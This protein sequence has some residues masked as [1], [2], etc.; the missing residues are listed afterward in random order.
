[1]SSDDAIARRRLVARPVLPPGPLAELKNALYGMYLSADAPAVARIRDRIRELADGDEASDP[2]AAPSNDAIHAVLS[3]PALPANTRHVIAVAAALL[4]PH[5]V[6]GL[7]VQVRGNPRIERIRQLWEQAVLAEQAM[8]HRPPGAVRVREARPRLLGVH[9]AIQANVGT[10]NGGQLDGARQGDEGRADDQLPVYV[11]RDFD[12]EL[13][14]MLTAARECGGFVLLTGDSST[15]KTRALFEALRDVMPEWWLLHPASA[16][17]VTEFAAAP[18]KQTVVWLDE[19]QNHLDHRVGLRAATIRSLVSARVAVVGTLW[20]GEY[21]ARIAPR[22]AEEPDL[23]ANDRQLLHLA[24]IVSVPGEFSPAERHR[25]EE[26]ADTDRRIRIALDTEDAGFTQVMAA[27]PQLIDH[28]EHAPAEH[29]YGK[30]VITAAL[31]ARRVGAQTP[32]TRAYLAAAA[33]GYLTSA[34]QATAPADWLDRALRYATAHLHGAACALPP[35]SSGMGQ[36]AGY[37]VAGYLHQH[38][39]KVRR[40]KPIAE[41]VWEAIIRHHHPDDRTRLA[42]NAERRDLDH[43]A[44]TLY[45]LSAAT[46]DEVAASWLTHRL[47]SQGRVDELR[48]R[49][50]AGDSSAGSRLARLLVEQ[51]SV[52]DAIV[53]LRQHAGDPFCAGDLARVLVDRGRVEEAIAVLREHAGNPFCAGDLARVLVDVGNVEEAIAVLREHAGSNDPNPVMQLAELLIE[54]GRIDDAAAVLRLRADAGSSFPSMRLARLLY[55]RDQVDELRKRADAGDTYAAIALADV[56][57]EQ[58]QVDELRNRV[59][60]GDGYAAGAL[61]WDLASKGHIDDA[62]AVMRPHAATGRSDHTSRFADLL[63]AYDRVDELRQRAEAGD[64]HAA[65]RLAR[66]LVKQGNVDDA[67]A[68]LRQHTGDWS[69]AH[70]LARLLAK[71]DRVDE[72]RQLTEAGDTTAGLLLVDL[73]ADKGE[74]D[75]VQAEVFAGTP[76]AASRMAALRS[77]STIPT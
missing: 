66:R 15:G 32:V 50:E 27:G 55:E 6:P 30:A 29:C 63:V 42:R 7:V 14:S 74:I 5:A 70:D 25:A 37:D 38:A 59:N 47:A 41:V 3:S 60:A 24:E 54:H 46:G 71:H 13:H 44:E 33:P 19:L 31:D 22:I 57:F 64:S 12:V 36:I 67:I 76:G 40:T 62:I 11:P 52:D 8:E 23:Y 45:R 58:G 73:L 56:L 26:L 72:L 68:V 17:I 9:A 4:Y 49:A 51:G 28:W 39:R 48:R 35:V 1:M 53:V 61:A 75:E 34:Q 21:A 2:T 18:S 69:S 16:A 10:A 65:S 20:P 43:H 77:A